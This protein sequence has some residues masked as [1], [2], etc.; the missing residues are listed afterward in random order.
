MWY[1]AAR[2]LIVAPFAM[3]ERVNAASGKRTLSPMFFE[4][5]RI[6]LRAIFANKL[7]ASLTV[8]GVMIG[9]AS[10]IAVISLVQGMQY[11][12]SNDLQS[13][14]S[15]YIEVFPDSGERRKQIQ[16]DG[17]GFT[18]VGIME[19]KGGSFGRD[20]DDYVWIPFTTAASIYGTENM[21]RIVAAF[22]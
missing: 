17:N 15:N 13:V 11:K 22:Q 20:Q 6:A 16:I 5:L 2:T 3:P 19:K 8:L 4:N 10:V 9:V 7:R 12:I 1:A 18:V 21:R 14:G